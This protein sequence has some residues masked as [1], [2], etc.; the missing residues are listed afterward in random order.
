MREQRRGRGLRGRGYPKGNGL[1]SSDFIG[2]FSQLEEALSLERFGRYLAWGNGGR[3]E[4]IS[5]YTLNT[6]ISESLYTPIQMLEVALRNRIH[7]VLTDMLDEAWILDKANLLGDHQPGQVDQAIKKIEK[8]R[9]DPTPDRIVAALSLSFW[10]AMLGRAYE[11]LW[12]DG[13]YQIAK[14]DDGKNL[15]RKDLATP[16]MRIRELRNRIA[17]HEPILYWDLH[18]THGLLLQLTHWLSPPAAEWCHKHSRFPT[19]C[20]SELHLRIKSVRAGGSTPES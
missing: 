12:R 3:E 5:L 13:L 2:S 17:H 8:E 1:T 14:R 19:V 9:R 18:K 10:T 15:R 20:P 4:A 11:Q 7:V 16:L 6:E